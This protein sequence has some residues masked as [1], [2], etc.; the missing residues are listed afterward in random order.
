[1]IGNPDPAVGQIWDTDLGRTY[2]DKPRLKAICSIINDKITW[3]KQD[4]FTIPDP[5]CWDRL[6]I[7][8]SKHY[9]FISGP[10]NII[11]NKSRFDLLLENDR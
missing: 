5:V 2:E 10:V 8:D 6:T 1:M 4:N 9:K 3:S 11:K 7:K